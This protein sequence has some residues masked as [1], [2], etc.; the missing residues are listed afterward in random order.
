[1]FCSD[2]LEIVKQRL[3]DKDDKS[4]RYTLAE[5]HKKFLKMFAPLLSHTTEE[6]WNEMYQNT[7]IHRSKWPEEE[8]V[9]ADKEAGER[10]MEVISAIRKF[11]TQSQLPLNEELSQ[12][13]VYGD[14]S[15]F[16]KPIKQVMHIQELTQL[17]Q[18][19][20]TEEKVIEISLNYEEAGPEYGDKVTEIEDALEKNEWM[21]E[22][23]HLDVA[24]EH[25]KPE[26]FEVQEERK[27]TGQG[28]MLETEN[29]LVIV[30]SE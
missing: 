30:R 6:I 7:S 16:Q 25:L 8:N 23:G 17:D 13:E 5:V 12:V 15:G 9:S 28:Q 14:I 24:G 21:I 26:E 27:Y 19:P 20:E 1:M 11:K 22:D 10:A 2:Y 3:D 4:A 29:S 18:E